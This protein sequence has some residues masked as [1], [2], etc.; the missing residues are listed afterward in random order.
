[1][2][3]VQ[4]VRGWNKL[5]DFRVKSERELDE[6]AHFEEM[7]ETIDG[8]AENARRKLIEFFDKSLFAR[9]IRNGEGWSYLWR[10]RRDR[11]EM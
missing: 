11:L 5:I 8:N 7:R 10:K 4:N 9:A 6:L 1:M 2:V 3:S